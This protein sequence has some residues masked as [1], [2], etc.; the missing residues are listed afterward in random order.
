MSQGS[1]PRMK[2]AGLFSGEYRNDFGHLHYRKKTANNACNPNQDWERLVLQILRYLHGCSCLHAEMRN[3]CPMS[4]P[5]QPENGQS[6][7]ILG[8]TTTS[9]YTSKSGMISKL[10]NL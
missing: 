5:S 6:L 2:I 1:P 3:V 10:S 8:V 9:M 7:M 4:P